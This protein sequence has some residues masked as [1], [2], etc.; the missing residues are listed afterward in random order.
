MTDYW[1]VGSVAE[2]KSRVEI[3]R[4]PMNVFDVELIMSHGALQGTQRNFLGK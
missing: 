2:R 1:I 3:S 4:D